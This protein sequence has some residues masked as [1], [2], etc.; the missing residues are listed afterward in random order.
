M[1]FEASTY[2]LLLLALFGTSFQSAHAQEPVIFNAAGFANVQQAVKDFQDFLGGMDNG[3]EPGP[4]DDG[5]RSINWD[6]AAV[7]FDMPGN[8]FRDTVTRGILLSV[9][10][11]E[12][13]VSNPAKDDPG[14]PDNLFDSINPQYPKQF[15]AFSPERIFSPLT[16]NVFTAEF[17]IPGSP[18]N[19]E[20]WIAGFGAI[21]VDV[22]NEKVSSIEYFD[23]EGKSLGSFPVVADPQGLSFL[24]VYF[25]D[26]VVGS[27]EV[28]LGNAI[29]GVDDFPPEH[30]VV[31]MDDFFFS[32]PV[33]LK[34]PAEK[35]AEK[36]AKSPGLTVTTTPAPPTKSP[37]PPSGPGYDR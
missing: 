33:A 5:F 26:D 28:T 1:N 11:D 17:S 4:I 30:E 36:P 27:V 18:K 37:S 6:A 15:Q 29:L 12:F 20:A 9:K 2:L 7:P 21:F 13:R 31:V 16:H 34:K 23:P 22:D 32:E 35:P 8:F 3:N 25:P 14:F 19:D 10:G 24:G